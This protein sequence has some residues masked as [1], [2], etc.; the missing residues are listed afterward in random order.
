MHFHFSLWL[1]DSDDCLTYSLKVFNIPMHHPS[2]KVDENRMFYLVSQLVAASYKLQDAQAE[3]TFQ[4][5]N[6]P[7]RFRN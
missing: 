4:P 3:L 2:A 1:I 7:H 6:G 5:N